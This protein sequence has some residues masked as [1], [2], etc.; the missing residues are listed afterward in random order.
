VRTNKELV[1]GQQSKAKGYPES[2]I[3]C[4]FSLIARLSETLWHLL[5]QPVQV[6]TT[7]GLTES[8]LEGTVYWLTD[9]EA[10]GSPKSKYSSKSG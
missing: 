5:R 4:D 6:E 2:R 8:S 10:P 7:L 9:T 3:N 1:T